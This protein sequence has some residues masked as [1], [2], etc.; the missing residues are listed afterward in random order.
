MGRLR[1]LL[2]AC[3][4]LAAG[5]A[6][7][8]DDQLHV[9]LAFEQYTLP[10]GLKVILR[11]D[12]R[13]PNVAVD[14]WYRVG[15]ANEGPGRTGFA[16]LFEHMMFQ[17]T[18]HV[19]PGVGDELLD[20]A[21]ATN[22]NATTNLDYTN[23]YETVPPSALELA[24]WI[25][26][27][28]M[29]FLLDTLDQSRL[30]NQQAVVRNERRE[31]FEEPPY[32]LTAEA[33]DQQ[34]YPP[35]H[36]YRARIIG[37]HTDIQAARLDDVRAFFTQYY[38]PNNATLSIVGH[39]DPAAT[40]AMI[41][42]YFGSIARGP[43]V[44]APVVVTPPLTAEKRITVTDAVSLPA[45]T[46]K[47]LTPPAYAPGNAD[48]DLAASVLA[49][50]R[51][52]RLYDALV[53]RTGIAQSVTAGQDSN[54]YASSFEIN[55]VAAPGHTAAELEAAIQ[56][57]LDAMA[58]SGPSAAEVEAA[59]TTTRS[60]LLFSLEDVFAVADRLDS[61]DFYLGDAARMDRDL[62]QYDG[63]NP[64][65]VRRFVT[66]QLRR[67]RRVV[68]WTVP[69]P[70]VRPPDPP[71][72]P[73]PPAVD[74]PR[75]PSAEPWRD[76]PPP[77]GP[78]PQPAL[79][80]AQR[81]VLRNG[82]PVYLVESHALPLASAMLISRRGTATTRLEKP[83]LAGL[84]TSMLVEGTRT[85]DAA[86]ID[87]E[88]KALGS[89]LSTGTSDDSSYVSLS[90]LVPQLP[91]TLAVMSDVVRESTFP[92][93]PLDRLR[94]E[95]L[96]ALD[97][98]GDDPD[99]I[100]ENT[101]WRELYGPAHP[102]S[103]ATTPELEQSLRSITVA[104]VQAFHRAAFTPADTALVLTGDLTRDRAE[105]LAEQAFGDWTGPAAGAVPA[106]PGP[107][108]PSPERVFLVDQPG[109]AQTTLLLAQP[110]LARSDPDNERLT[111][112]DTVLGGGVS[113]RLFRN[114]RERNGYT[115]NISSEA[116]P[117][118]GV[119]TITVR[120]N[121]RADAT[122]AAVREIL[123]EVRGLRDAPP[124]PDELA[125]ARESLSRSLPA[126]FT[127][128]S[129]LA[130]SVGA[131]YLNDLPLDTFRK[132]PETYAGVTAQDVRNV[133]RAH[134]DPD[135]MKIIVVGDRSVV[136]PQLAALG[137]GPIAHRT[138]EGTP[139]P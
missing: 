74:A 104:D 33:V 115:Y 99:A 11:E 80:A 21:G 85:R 16:H 52:S 14:L 3:V 86:A 51:T 9:D 25:K 112:A 5:C 8:E 10:N 76:T 53:L 83:G 42:K 106:P 47:W 71:A 105:E 90:A 84:A 121:V 39:I 31:N 118:R 127:T 44:P 63:L 138:P 18:G 29:G 37:S 77:P 75:P 48:G 13:Q 133:A 128:V 23:F 40:K 27:D 78:T 56:R 22:A 132:L 87:R 116:A 61:Y 38:V 110:G 124:G 65:T 26:S 96:S 2:L 57:E 4:L 101:M 130:G 129:A 92:P 34:L 122:G 111:V 89:G 28:Q 30:A 17:G 20:A 139:T 107:P 35:G 59:R 81:F 50:S 68:A 15:P 64:D 137:L 54:K 120:T 131:L 7:A 1:A 32:A 79:P 134:L 24:L 108:A 73:P 67:D 94:S 114:L 55:A 117:K 45:V 46:M 60:Q 19:P 12:D 62:R 49:G 125:R 136:E 102:Y 113:S 98:L 88:L 6:G 103:T 82:L 70:K 43:D 97:Q 95:Q 93:A 36:P 126:A 58:G 66:D 91:A 69:G 135:R 41:E 109:A 119:G 123:G 100:A 72:P